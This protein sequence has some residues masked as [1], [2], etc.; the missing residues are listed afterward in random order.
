M[1]KIIDR[2]LIFLFSLFAIG[3]S[4]VLLVAA[5][6]WIP[7]KET[8]AFVAR[9]YHENVPAA[10]FIVTMVVVLLIA[11]RLFVIAVRPTRTNHA[12][13]DQR[14]EFGDIRISLETVEN[15]ALKAASRSRGVRDLKARVRVS[16]AGIEI[17]I[18][19]IIDGETSIP[20][21]TEEVQTAVKTHVEEITGIP[22]A[23]VSV[24]V[25]NIVQTSPTFKS[26]VE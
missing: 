16:N 11:I 17:E 6:N 23:V 4:A 19:T 3:A 25:A 18:R 26:R 21:L 8:N 12:S 1:A 14:T 24:F 10:A 15:L 9:V 5:F 20:D 2:F 13:I 22:V 7:E